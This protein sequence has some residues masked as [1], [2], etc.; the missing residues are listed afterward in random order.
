MKYV[1]WQSEGNVWALRI[2]YIDKRFA[3]SREVRSDSESNQWVDARRWR[4]GLLRN[5]FESNLTSKKQNKAPNVCPQRGVNDS[6]PISSFLPLSLSLTYSHFNSF[7]TI[8]KRDIFFIKKS[9]MFLHWYTTCVCVCVCVN[10]I[11][12]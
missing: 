8:K 10:W 6:S 9:G 5:C 2:S 7:V 3:V 11:W 12:H 1:N 4:L